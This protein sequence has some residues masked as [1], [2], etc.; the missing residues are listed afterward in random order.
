[1]PLAARRVL[2]SNCPGILEHNCYGPSRASYWLCVD[3]P[4]G[5]IEVRF[6]PETGHYCGF[7]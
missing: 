3:I 4:A 7:D 6:A 5:K 2:F 1:M